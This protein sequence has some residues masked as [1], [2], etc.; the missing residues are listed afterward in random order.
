MSAHGRVAE[1]ALG[2]AVLCKPGFVLVLLFKESFGKRGGC[3]VFF[4]LSIQSLRGRELFSIPDP[5]GIHL[6]LRSR[7][8]GL[9]VENTGVRS[10]SSMV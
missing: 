7:F 8:S 1:T 6:Q 2:R 3:S 9:W 10:F 4:M 5:R